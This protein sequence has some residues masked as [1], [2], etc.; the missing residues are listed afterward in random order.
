M[1]ESQRQIQKRETRKKIIYSAYEEFKNKGIIKTTTSD[2]AKAAGVSHGTIFAH[3]KTQG[4]LVKEVIE[5]FCTKIVMNTHLASK[6]AYT[7]KEVLSA[8]LEGIKEFEEFYGRLILEINFLE[9]EEKSTFI[10]IQSALSKH[11]SEALEIEVEAESIKKLP[12]SFIFNS[13]IGLVNYYIVNRELFSPG[14]S[15]IDTHKEEL[16]NNFIEL[17]KK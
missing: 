4:E 8:H 15:V 3:F 2:I 5:V 13:W 11:L 17:I 10:S 16:I 14:K 7:V 9:K 6:K 12:L 1:K